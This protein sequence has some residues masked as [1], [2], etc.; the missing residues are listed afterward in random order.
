MEQ[1]MEFN[2]FINNSN[3]TENSDN[4]TIKTFED[5]SDTLRKRY[6]NSYKCYIYEYV[7]CLN[8]CIILEG[9]FN[10]LLQRMK[11]KDFA[12]LSAYRKDFTKRENII[13]NRKLRK[14]LN[15]NK[16]GVHQLVGHWLEA[17]EGKDY[18]DC[19]KSEL[20]D[21][22]E[23][24]YFIAKP[25]NM[26]FQDFTDIIIQCLT[27][28]GVTQDCC[29]IHKKGGEYLTLNKEGKTESLG[30]N[31]TFNKIAQAYSEYVINKKSK[32]ATFVFEGVECPASNSAHFV[33]E[34]YKIHYSI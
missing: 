14:I 29:V 15:D 10:R 3:S 8:N 17:P 5:Y 16:M 27:I 2:E 18:K 4:F 20:T 12:I 33:F 28:D 11:N 22:I 19:D 30:N 9:S 24:S 23:R 6:S 7:D 21:V 32:N 34:K 1:I 13:R 25:D 26:S 31:V